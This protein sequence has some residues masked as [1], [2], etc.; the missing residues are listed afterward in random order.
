MFVETSETFV[1]KLTKYFSFLEKEYG[2]TIKLADNSDVRPQTDAI[3]KY[4]SHTTLVFVDSEFGRVAVRFNRIQ[5]AERYFLGPVTIHEYLNT[6]DAEKQTLLSKDPKTLDASK[7]ISKRVDLLAL[8]GLTIREDMDKNLERQLA[9]LAKW[10]KE[11][12]PIY[13][14]GDFS[15]W[16]EIYEYKINRLLAED[17]RQGGKETVTAFI[18][19]ENGVFKKTERHIF[20][21][22]REY[23]A[24]LHNELS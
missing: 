4:A 22:Q 10:V 20:H 8:S 7:E 6:T 23:L 5:D 12:A 11:H 21:D 17:L 9:I 15:K 19:D 13:L 16:P 3:V 1:N 2:F 14:I 24:K 18:R